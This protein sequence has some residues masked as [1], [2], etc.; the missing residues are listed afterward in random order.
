MIVVQVWIRLSSPIL[1]N[2]EANVYRCTKEESDWSSPKKSEF[3]GGND[4]WFCLRFS[5]V[6]AATVRWTT[7]R[8]F[9]RASSRPCPR[10]N[11]RRRR[12]LRPAPRRPTARRPAAVRHWARPAP[13]N[14][15]RHR[16][17]PAQSAADRRGR[18][19]SCPRA[20]STPSKKS[21]FLFIL[22][23]RLFADSFQS[24]CFQ[25]FSAATLCLKFIQFDWNFHSNFLRVTLLA[26]LAIAC[27]ESYLNYES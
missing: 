4:Q 5:V 2:Y 7:T 24:T 14:I 16:P 19:S 27:S 10:P 12:A 25:S 1:T 20:P 3:A 13:P 18:P 9:T 23:F 6:A 21:V 15:R 17:A 11:R 22:R 26:P 8:S